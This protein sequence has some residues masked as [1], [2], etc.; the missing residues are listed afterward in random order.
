M[1]WKIEKPANSQKSNKWSHLYCKQKESRFVNKETYKSGLCDPWIPLN[2][3][4]CLLF[5]FAQLEVLGCMVLQN[6]Y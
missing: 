4:I 3:W 1:Y 6:F 2:F 5:C